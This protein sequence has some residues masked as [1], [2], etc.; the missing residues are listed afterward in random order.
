MYPNIKIKTENNLSLTHSSVILKI[1]KKIYDGML[2]EIPRYF[3]LGLDKDNNIMFK[4]SPFRK[5][6]RPIDDITIF[7]MRCTLVG[8]GDNYKEKYWRSDW[9]IYVDENKIDF[10]SCGYPDWWSDK[11]KTL[12]FVSCDSSILDDEHITI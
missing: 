4:L 7:E 6:S 12:L 1:P 11:V 3:L 8:V 5:I 2:E 10:R 9:Y